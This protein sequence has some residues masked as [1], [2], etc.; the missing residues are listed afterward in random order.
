M[1]KKIKI[2][3]VYHYLAHYREP[4]FRELCSAVENNIEYT[5]VSGKY[6]NIKSIKTIEPKKALD[7]INDG[8]LNW[9]FIKN[10]WLTKDV[11]W[12]SGVIKLVWKKE[13]DG[14]IFLGNMYYL[15][16]WIAIIV[17]K[18]RG[19][20]TFLWTHGF[21]SDEKGM[22]GW[23]RS[24]FY[25]LSDSILLYGQRA[26]SIMTG[27]GFDVGSIYVINNSLD[28]DKQCSVRNELTSEKLKEYKEKYFDNPDWPVL[29]TTG[30]LIDSKKIDYLVKAVT[31]LKGK[32]TDVNLMII[33]DGPLKEKIKKMVVEN[34]IANRVVL[35]GA[36]YN[37][38]ELGP[39][40]SMADICVVPDAL[41]LAC[42][43]S[44]VY[45]TPVITHNQFDYHGPEAEAIKDGV[46][47]C[48]YEY[49][50]FSDLV[51]KIEVWLKQDRSRDEIKQI[52][53]SVVDNYY[54]PRYQK[55]M[56]GK[57]INE[58]L[59]KADV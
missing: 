10:Y 56:I 53:Q 41:G 37:E 32:G 42:V 8:G 14:V 15:S 38:D 25:K 6:S 34:N 16:T 35:Y 31:V 54:T 33:G 46:N 51:I 7:N 24:I 4:V 50:D 13:F 21:R 11:L 58:Q 52:C 44:L 29:I 5:I 20:H 57:A 17:A 30:R 40:I 1:E 18:F 48:L 3:I 27:K 47:G 45:G 39:M 22:K 19:V 59:S 43:H 36:C 49:G 55:T 12:Q 23:T 26:R 28:Y 9:R 2:A